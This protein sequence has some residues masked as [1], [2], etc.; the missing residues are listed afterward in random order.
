MGPHNLWSNDWC[1]YR[2]TRSGVSV[3][4]RVNRTRQLAMLEMLKQN[5]MH[6]NSEAML[7][8]ESEEWFRARS[9]H[10]LLNRILWYHI[11]CRRERVG[12]LLLRGA[13]CAWQ[14]LDPD[15]AESTRWLESL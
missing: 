9:E 1:A 13:L 14:L 2:N 8:R 7:G 12:K 5:L 11:L 4:G 6:L 10:Q 15:F 3:V